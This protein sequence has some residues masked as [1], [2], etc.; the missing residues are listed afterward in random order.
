M[1]MIVDKKYIPLDKYWT[2]RMGV[3]DIINGYSD[4]QNFLDKEKNLGGD[5]QALHRASKVWNTSKSV[6]VGESGTL[7]RFLQFISWK[8]GLNKKFV[9]R[10]TLKHRKVCNNPEIANWNLKQLLELDGGTSQ[11]ASSAIL[12]GNR[13]KISNPPYFIKKTYEALK[14]W[15]ERRKN[16]KRW[17]ARYDEIL[18]KQAKYFLNVLNSKRSIFKPTNPDDYCFARA[19]GV[20]T[21]AQGE[22]QWPMIRHHESDRLEEMEIALDQA[23]NNRMVMSKDHRV[24]HA[25]AM[26]CK[27]KNKKVKFKYPD[28]VNKS[29]PQFWDFLDASNPAKL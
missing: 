22:K 3:L 14:H 17:D 25:I 21:K 28:S 6:D 8:Q 18:L 1:K 15:D 24:I 27:T 23:K 4:I 7:Y 20:M 2:I 12:L 9:K 19:F 13:E 11:W 10:G 29:W 26:L 16:K 5:I